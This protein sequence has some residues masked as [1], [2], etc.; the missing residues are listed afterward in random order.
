MSLQAALFDLG[1][2]VLDVDFDLA[3]DHWARRSRL[4]ADEVRRR[5]A[6]DGVSCRSTNAATKPAPCLSPATSGTCASCLR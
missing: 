4:P 5:F 3:L 2:V 1:G 6:V